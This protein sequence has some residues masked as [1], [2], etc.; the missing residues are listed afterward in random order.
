[1]AKSDKIL[2]AHGGG[3]VLS[4]EL[5]HDLIAKT[6]GGDALRE[7]GDS[8]RLDLSSPRIAFTTDSF[9]V[10]PLFFPGGDI[11]RLAVCGTVNDLSVAGAEPKVLSLALILEE[12]FPITDLK[13]ILTSVR[14]TAAEAGVQI[15]TG[16]TKVLPRGEAQDLFVN[17]AGIGVRYEGVE[18]APSNASPGDV[19]LINGEI[20]A[21]GATVI[22]RRNGV[23]L[24]TIVVSDVAPLG[25]LVERIVKACP[26]V[27]VMRDATRGGV[28]AVL[29]EIAQASGVGFE[30]DEASIPVAPN[31]ARICD[32]LG[33]D[34]LEV[35]NEGKVVV[36]CPAD[37]AEVVVSAMREDPH[38][39]SACT[40][41]RAIE[42]KPAKVFLNTRVGGRRL[43]EMPYGESLPRIC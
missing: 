35:P 10:Q 25:A 27:K 18:I 31:V 15:V 4:Q 19:V 39:K 17:T 41:G 22:A 24:D 30:I 11:G 29:N 21:H 23:H 37:Q 1:M 5:I 3:G 43:V 6:L 2:L 36:I 26:G 42:S 28:S 20:A 8:A 40:I 7:M 13:T 33:F 34:P 12:G 9:I 16:D 32:L 14:E 38:G